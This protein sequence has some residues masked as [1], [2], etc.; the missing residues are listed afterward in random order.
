MFTPEAR[1]VTPGWVKDRMK[2]VGF[3]DIEE[4]ELVPGMT[5]LIHARKPG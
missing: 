4:N 2:E 5:R 3:T 1:S